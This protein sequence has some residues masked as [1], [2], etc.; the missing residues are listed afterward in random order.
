M[1]ALP[2][3]PEISKILIESIKYNC[4]YEVAGIISLLSYSNGIFRRN[5]N[6][7]IMNTIEKYKL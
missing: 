4:S 6:P 3:E 2:T 7:K 5:P 1:L